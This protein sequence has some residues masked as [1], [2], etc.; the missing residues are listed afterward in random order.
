MAKI[1]VPEEFRTS[2]S[3]EIF[4]RLKDS[5]LY[6][7]I[8]EPFDMGWKQ[9]GLDA[10]LWGGKEVMM[11]ETCF[12]IAQTPRENPCFD[13]EKVEKELTEIIRESPSTRLVRCNGGKNFLTSYWRLEEGK[14][15][16]GKYIIKSTKI[17]I[18]PAPS[19]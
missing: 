13:K 17:R 10:S 19:L 7:P 18:I 9:I 5:G 4:R 8:Q 16:L 11:R 15:Y 3:S 6:V 12:A 1:Y 2:T 14:N